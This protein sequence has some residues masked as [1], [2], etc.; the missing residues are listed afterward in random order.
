MEHMKVKRAG[1]TAGLMSSLAAALF[2]VLA[3]ATAKAGDPMGADSC[4]YEGQQYSVGACIRSVC[5]SPQ[6]QQCKAD[7]TWGACSGCV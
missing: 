1:L 3:P 4:W 2:V 5:S 7:G 6:A